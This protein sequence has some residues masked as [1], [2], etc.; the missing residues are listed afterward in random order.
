MN[1]ASIMILAWCSSIAA[2]G[3]HGGAPTLDDLLNLQKKRPVEVQDE[4]EVTDPIVRRLE[5]GSP[6]DTFESAVSLMDQVARRISE[7]LDPGTETQRLQ[8]DIV[9]RLDRVI[10]A[11]R[12]QQH[13]GSSSESSSSD[14]RPPDSG[15]D[16]VSTP[17][18]SSGQGTSSGQLQSG[19]SGSNPGL[20]SPGSVGEVNAEEGV[21][22]HRRSEWGNLPPRLRDEL[23]EGLKERFSSTYR[24]LTEAYYQR[25]AQDQE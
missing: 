8:E 22:Q 11:A 24:S 17:S 1:R 7:R 18:S 21:M 23:S 25:L 20:A 15:S 3:P 10:A 14:A 9:L 16:S 19:G 6:E 4:P 5:G 12:R 13:Q 2:A